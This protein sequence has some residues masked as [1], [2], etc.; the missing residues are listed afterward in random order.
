MPFLSE[1]LWQRLPRRQGDSTP[2]IVRAA[3]PEYDAQFDDAKSAEQ[4]EILISCSRGLRSLMS[5]FGIKKDGSGEL[6][7]R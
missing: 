6:T 1:E 2:S 7:P 4:Y 5:E 3:Y